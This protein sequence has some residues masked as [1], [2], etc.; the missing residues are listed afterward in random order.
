MGS[1]YCVVCGRDDVPT[2]DGVCADCFA[3]RTPLVAVEG[4]PVVVLCP[5]CGARK[6]GQLWE[7][8]GASS[9]LTSQDLLPFLEVHPEVGVRKVRWS[10]GG[11]N[12]LL[13]DIEASAEVSVRGQKR[14][15]T[16]RFEVKIEH[17]TCP[18]CSRRSGH[19]YTAVIQLRG[20]EDG[21]R[22][23]PRELRSRLDD[24]W[25]ALMPE[26]RGASKEAISWKEEKPEGWDFYLTDTL[27]ART[28]VRLG[29][30]R[31]GGELKESATLWGRKHGRDVYRVTF[32]LRLPAPPRAPRASSPRR[33]ERQA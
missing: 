8:R 30:A 3:K 26:V 24:Q 29:K 27:A 15:E 18:E 22:E 6:V 13:R 33:V 17:H 12:A 5:T 11:R 32:C 2:T 20:M 23:T 16:V 31:L 10:E 28:I 1:E 4:R 21:P 19:F 7:R 25:D 9:L 14:T